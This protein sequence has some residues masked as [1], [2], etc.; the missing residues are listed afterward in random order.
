MHSRAFGA[1]T[2]PPIA[3]CPYPVELHSV[4]GEI[5]SRAKMVLA[6]YTSET[7]IVTLSRAQLD[8]LDKIILYSHR[9][10]SLPDP[11]LLIVCL[12]HLLF[13]L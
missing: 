7:G 1:S 11:L 6:A 4:H 10:K 5:C 3:R 2:A 12:C 13:H 9:L 8:L